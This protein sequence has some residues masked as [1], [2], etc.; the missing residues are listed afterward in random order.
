MVHIIFGISYMGKTF[1][2]AFN[3]EIIWRLFCNSL[4]FGSSSTRM[5][6][7]GAPMPNFVVPM[8]QQGKQA[9]HPSGGHRGPAGAVALCRSHTT[10]DVHWFYYG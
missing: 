3:E 8:V 9:A 10:P 4:N 7:A 6:P 2:I 5:R 1:C